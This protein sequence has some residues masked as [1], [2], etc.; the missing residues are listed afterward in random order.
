MAPFTLRWGIMA[1]G[2]IA[3]KFVKDLLTDPSVRG[4]DDVAHSL[5]AVASSSSASRAEA[6]LTAVNYAPPADSS[7]VKTYGSY[8]EL[9]ADP[10]VD[11]IYVATPHS[12]HFQ[13]AMLALNAGKHVLCEKALT[14]TAAQA[15]ALV[16]TARDKKL[17]LMEAVWTRFF[18]ISIKIR[19]MVRSGEIGHVYRVFAD[20]SLNCDG[21]GDGTF[22]IDD[23]HRLI[24]PD[25]A[26]GATLDLGI[27]S[28]TWVFQVL[29]HAQAE[30]ETPVVTSAMNL[31][32]TGADE[33]T[34]LIV[35]FPKHRSV[36]VATCTL[37]IET[38]P[39]KLAH[40]GPL[41]PSIRIQGSKA[42]VQVFGTAAHPQ[43]YRI[44]RTGDDDQN[45]AVVDCPI[46][47]D[48]KRGGWGHGMFWEADECAR[49]VRD[50]KLESETMPLDE[51]VLISEVMDK[52]LK[53]NGVTYPELIAT[54]VF[55]AQSP[56][57][58]G[59]KSS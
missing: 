8:A 49:C 20:L 19:E 4:V 10:D 15:K 12:H 40:P 47:A 48:E 2:G 18:P 33:N 39:N 28:L 56:L 13:N 16:R 6:F 53:E 45:P 32:H 59:N 5:R 3:E 37:R 30:R 58:A 11:I 51:T 44:V 54:D 42:E 31:A 21:G 1:T 57:N 7:S 41:G 9:V 26:G 55:D 52:A 22:N 14:V 50:G 29:Y 23:S 43:K 24:N 38:C 27:Y 46:P 36:G 25:L 17:F 34:T 35:Q